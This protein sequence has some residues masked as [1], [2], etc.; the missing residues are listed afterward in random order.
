[1]LHTSFHTTVPQREWR[2]GGLGEG[3]PLAW[4]AV[5]TLMEG[6]EGITDLM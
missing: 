2:G 6:G 3:C 5:A 4:L 1:M